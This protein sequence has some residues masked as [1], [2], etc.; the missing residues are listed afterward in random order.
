M[1]QAVKHVGDDCILVSPLLM[2]Y[3]VNVHMDSTDEKNR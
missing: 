3:V 2:F 1:T